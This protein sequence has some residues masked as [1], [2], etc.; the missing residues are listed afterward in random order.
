MIVIRLMGGLGNT[1]FQYALGRSLESQGKEVLFERGILDAC[2]ARTYL[3]DDFH[4]N[5]RF[6]DTVL[7]P[8]ITEDGMPFRPEVFAYDNRTLTGYWQTE[9]YFSNIARELRSELTPTYTSAR[10]REA[11][12]R[13]AGT[14]SVALHIRRSDS[15]SAR[16]LPFHGLL[17]ET[18]YY[19]LAIEHVRKRLPNPEFF[20]FSDDIPWCM[21]HLDFPATFVSHNAMSGECDSNGIVTKGY[22]GRECEDIWLMS[23][24]RHAVIANSS[25]SWWGAWLGDNKPDRLVVAP[26]QWFVA[27]NMDARDIVPLR[28]TTL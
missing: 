5:I 27:L 22:R 25:F 7:A 10:T 13:M 17:C 15:L 8:E 9:K 2:S 1:L 4:T 3:L 16:A 24:C 6:T 14:N 19:N 26:K 20:V 18:D 23:Q 12:S 28:W 11:A 21:N